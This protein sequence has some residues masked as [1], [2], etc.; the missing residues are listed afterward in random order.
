MKKQNNNS[1]FR[2]SLIITI[3]AV[4]LLVSASFGIYS[5]VKDYG[6]FGGY[7]AGVTLQEMEAVPVAGEGEAPGA[8]DLQL[9]GLPL[10][11]AGGLVLKLAVSPGE[12]F[13]RPAQTA[14]H[15]GAGGALQ[16]QL[17]RTFRHGAFL[18]LG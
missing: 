6:W 13:Q 3:V 12:V 18:L 8:G 1:H 7:E 11:P 5:M 4:C 10:G 14:G 15:Q 9:Q 17:D 16:A 2:P